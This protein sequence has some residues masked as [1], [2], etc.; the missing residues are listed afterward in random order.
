MNQIYGNNKLVKNSASIDLEWVPYTGE[1]SHTKTKVISAAFCTN[2]GTK[3][4]LHI[5]QFEK[6]ANPERQLILAILKYLDNFNLTFG[7]YTTGI[8]KYD[9]NTRDYLDGRDSDFFI[10]DK[11]CKY[12]NLPSPVAYSQ[13]GKSTFLQ[14]RK[15]IDL[16]KVYGKEIIRRGVFNDR[17]RTLHLEEV[18]QELSGLGKYTDSNNNEKVTGD[19]AYLHSIQEQVNYVKRDA[20]LV[21]ML[22]CYNDCLVLRIMEL[23]AM[24]SEMDYTITCHTGVT[25]WYANIYDKMIERDECTLQSSEHKI[26]NQKIAGGNSIKPKKGFY[27]NEPIDEL[28]V[29]GMYPTIAIER[30][31]SFETVNC[32]CCK[33]NPEARI[34]SEVMDE[35]NEK[36][37]KKSL[38]IREETYWI[39]MLRKGAF[40][41]KL[42]QLLAEREKYQQLAKEE[43]AKPS[44]QQKQEVTSYYEARQLALKLLANAGYGAFAQKEFAYYDYRVSEI[45]TGF[46]RLIHKKMEQIGFERYGFQT[47]FGFTDSIF[48]RHNKTQIEYKPHVIVTSV[49]NDCNNIERYDNDN[50]PQYLNDCLHE[51]KVRLEHKNRFMFTIIFDKKNRYIAWTGNFVD[52]PILKNLDG[53][54]RRYPKWIKQQIENIATQLITKPNIDVSPLIRQAFEDLDYGRFDP[55]DLQFTEQL[56]KN[57]NQ[58][59]NNKKLRVKVLAIELGTGIGEIVYWY[60][61]LSNERGYST[62]V[63]D[64]SIKK[65][66]EILWDK[67]ED[68]LQIAGYEVDKIK[69]ELIEGTKIVQHIMS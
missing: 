52:R 22:A 6:Y 28:D 8:A 20:E 7:W 49:S 30:N 64:I 11:R 18:S 60:E 54:N 39:C 57:P 65:Y 38:P 45:I 13:S 10:L 41:T 46:G 14:N 50:I 61:S 3:I 1:Y 69:S 53:M 62:K 56:D 44:N 40:P 15:H 9:P 21:M 27:K 42:K 63:K 35:I 48:V 19:N 43:L 47:V 24:Y 26:P 55:K 66:K 16:Y 58:Y 67:I 36:L 2:L 51:L 59:P 4:V 23:I 37:Q 68:M 32:K 12:H 29:K 25:K 34:P 17:Y 31:I 5:S 33:D